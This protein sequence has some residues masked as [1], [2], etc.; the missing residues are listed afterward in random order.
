M[1]K[2]FVCAIMLYALFLFGC[3]SMVNIDTENAGNGAPSYDESNEQSVVNDV[4][5]PV[6]SD[7]SEESDTPSEESSADD[8][9]VDDSVT[10][11]FD[12]LYL[13]SEGTSTKVEVTRCDINIAGYGEYSVENPGVVYCEPQNGDGAYLISLNVEA[14]SVTV[15]SWDADMWAAGIVGDGIPV[16]LIDGTAVFG[17]RNIYCITV[18]WYE[19]NPLCSGKAEYWFAVCEFID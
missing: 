14:D 16:E 6:F 13:L 18:E 12:C 19:D 7:V 4:S 17:G 10:A 15:L 1:K 3:N 11:D 5:E 8:S 2:T 9:S